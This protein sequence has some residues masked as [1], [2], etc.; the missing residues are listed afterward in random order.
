MSSFTQ[1]HKGE[2][3][4]CPVCGSHPV[5]S[6]LRV[7]DRDG[8]RYLVCSLCA[9]EWYAPRARCTNCDTPQEVSRLGETPDSLV[10]GECCDDCGGYIKIMFQSKDPLMDPGADDLATLNLD[11]ALASEG[12][13]RTGRN[14]FFVTGQDEPLKSD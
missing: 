5:T 10:Q 12:Y 14:L 13:Q 6:V 4:L 3:G 9:S 11:L 7:G 8:H 2:N 1:L